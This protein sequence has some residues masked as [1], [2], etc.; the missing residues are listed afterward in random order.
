SSAFLADPVPSSAQ[1]PARSSP[2]C[3]VALLLS[4]GVIGGLS[5][6]AVATYLTS[7]GATTAA[8]ASASSPGRSAAPSGSTL[9]LPPPSSVA[10]SSF[11][12]QIV[13]VVQDLLPSVVTVINY[14]SSGQPQSSGSGF[15]V[16]ASRGYVVA[17]NPV[18]ENVRDANAGDPR[19]LPRGSPPDG[20]GD[21]RGELRRAAHLGGDPSG[22][23]RE[24]ARRE[25][26]DRPRVR[27]L[28]Q[29]RATG[30]RRAHPEREDP[31]RL[32]RHPVHAA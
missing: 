30:R 31:A 28:E 21:Q 18:V 2:T 1:T 10:P 8:P 26:R 22:H 13:G 32:H 12:Q 6:G 25:Q 19:H 3:P 7:S 29:H 23:R 16:D 17:N 20:R 4:G 9:P 5:G 15:V 14:A 24:H 11:D 27:D